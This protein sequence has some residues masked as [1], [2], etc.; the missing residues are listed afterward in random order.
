MFIGK[1]TGIGRLSARVVSSLLMPGLIA[2][3]AGPAAAQTPAPTAPAKPAAAPAAPAKPA[4]PPAAA[5]PAK[6]A[7]P[8]AAA[9]P[10]KPAPPPAAAAP[11]KPAPPPAAAA[12]AKPAPPPAAPPPA[13]APAKPAP[14]PVVAVPPPVVAA[15]PP[16]VAAPPSVTVE[17]PPPPAPVVEPAAPGVI[18]TTVSP[19]ELSPEEL[20]ELESK[21]LDVV[22]VTVDWREKSIQDYAGSASVYKQDQLD[23]INVTSLRKLADTDPHMEIGTQEGNTEIFIRGVGGADNTELGDP[24]TSTYFGDVYIPRPRGVGSMF[25][26]LDRVEVNRGPQGTLRGRNATAGTVNL[27]PALPR[28]ASS[29]RWLTSNTGTTTTG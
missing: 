11:A 18:P 10:A 16:V 1:R 7:P 19:E 4:P 12:A 21:D 20:A 26:D 9:A 28:L 24:A 15:P 13:A 14:P 22:K 27:I 2:L 29:S 3:G 8:P 5:A 25:F 17:A 23:R 6:P